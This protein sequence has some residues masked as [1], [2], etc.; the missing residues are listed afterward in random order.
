[1]HLISPLPLLLTLATLFT[2]VLAA[3]AAAPRPPTVPYC[4]CECGLRRKGLTAADAH[5]QCTKQV[6]T[7]FGEIEGIDP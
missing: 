2:A 3:P 1:M 4:D 5:T 7:T 6:G